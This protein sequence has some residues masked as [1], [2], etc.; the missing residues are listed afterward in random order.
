MQYDM[1]LGHEYFFSFYILYF[2]GYSATTNAH[3]ETGQMAVCCQNLTLG[4]LNSRS[5]LY[6]LVG[7]LFEKFRLFLNTPRVH[8]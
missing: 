4:V 8:A 7:V 2:R 5:A 3:S 1:E 6:V